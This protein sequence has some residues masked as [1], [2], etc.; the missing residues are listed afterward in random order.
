MPLAT[1][2]RRRPALLC[3][4]LLA[5]A[6]AFAEAGGDV[7]IAARSESDLA[8]VADRIRAAG[9]RAHAVAVDL[10]D[11]DAAA[12]LAQTAV[13][14]F[15]RLDTVVNNVGGAMPRPLFDTQIAAA[16]AGVGGGMGIATIIERV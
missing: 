9:R 8:Q 3:A 10:A 16:L 14:E 4:P 7:V 6:V 11:P 13:D 15:G 1:R 5:I 12:A 2:A